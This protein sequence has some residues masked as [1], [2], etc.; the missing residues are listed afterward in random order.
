MLRWRRGAHGAAS[1]ALPHLTQRTHASFPDSFS[2]P[3]ALRDNVL[4]ETFEVKSL[5]YLNTPAWVR[6]SPHSLNG[7]DC[8]SFNISM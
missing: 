6:P 4:G 3:L 8:T 5:P 2:M 1:Q 7:S